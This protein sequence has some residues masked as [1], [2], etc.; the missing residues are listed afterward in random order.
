MIYRFE[1]LTEDHVYEGWAHN[2][3][4]MREKFEAQ[5]PGVDCEVFPGEN[6]YGLSI[7]PKNI[8]LSVYR[9]F[10]SAGGLRTKYDVIALDEAIGSL[11]DD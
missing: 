3:K 11:C 2:P 4:E 5:F 1:I 6:I 9:V 10:S 7:A 8:P